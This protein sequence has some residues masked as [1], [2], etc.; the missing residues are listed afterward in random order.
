MKYSLLLPC[1]TIAFRHVIASP[2]PRSPQEGV[3]V[4]TCVTASQQCRFDPKEADML[5]SSCGHD[6]DFT[7]IKEIASSCLSLVRQLETTQH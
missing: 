5:C 4:G 3:L 2:R 7:W 6:L 1:L